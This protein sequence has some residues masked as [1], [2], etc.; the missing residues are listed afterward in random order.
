MNYENIAKSILECVGGKDNISNALHCSTRIRLELHNASDANL[1]KIKEI[2][3]V[4]GAVNS[5]GQCQVII[6]N[7]VSLFLIN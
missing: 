2:H 5:G 1:E 7:D 6:G 4:M 3:G